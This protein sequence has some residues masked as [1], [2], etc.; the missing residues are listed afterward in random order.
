MAN[1]A[2]YAQEA[3]DLLNGRLHLEGGL[4]WDYFR[5][6]V[7]NGVNETPT[8]KE[9]FAGVE[10]AARLQPKISAAYTVSDRVPLTFYVNYGR[11]INSQDARGVVRTV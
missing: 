5:F 4:R 1:F 3:I 2:G 6:N 10:S 9:F 8:S 11:G 7:R